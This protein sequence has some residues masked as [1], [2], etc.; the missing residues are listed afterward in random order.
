MECSKWQ[1]GCLLEIGWHPWQ[2]NAIVMYEKL[3]KEGEE[4][5]KAIV[6]D[7]NKISKDHIHKSLDTWRRKEDFEEICIALA[8]AKQYITSRST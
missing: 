4:L 1:L 7:L 2:V 5:F 6:Y 8:L 3:L